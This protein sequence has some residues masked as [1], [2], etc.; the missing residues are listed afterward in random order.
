MP[1]NKKYNE[2]LQ[3]YVDTYKSF[4]SECQEKPTSSDYCKAFTEYFANKDLLSKFKCSLKPSESHHKGLAADN[5][6][7]VEIAPV[8]QEIKELPQQAVIT[9][10]HAGDTYHAV[11]PHPN[12]NDLDRSSSEMHS[13]SEHLDHSPPSTIKKSIATAA[14]AAGLLVPPFLVYNFTPV[15]SWINKLLGR[16]QIYRNPL[17]ERELIENSYQPYHFDSE[18]NRY[19]ISYRPE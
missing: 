19:N 1:C 7:D 9:T 14:S 12:N 11:H 13:D 10:A 18:R 4:E 2:H 15:R 6:A 8:R 3:K 17:I 16:N 5:K